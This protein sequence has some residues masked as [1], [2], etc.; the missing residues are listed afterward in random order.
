MVSVPSFFGLLVYEAITSGDIGV[1]RQILSVVVFYVETIKF[2]AC[3]LAI[4][5]I[6]ELFYRGERLRW[7]VSQQSSQ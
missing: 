3:F 6:L 5:T 4:A 2:I 1:L 7:E